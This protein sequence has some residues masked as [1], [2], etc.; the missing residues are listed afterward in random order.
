MNLVNY[1]DSENS[2][3]ESPVIPKVV[4]KPVAAK[5]SF[6]KVVDSSNPRKI[7]VNLPTTS[8]TRSSDG[9]IDADGPPAKKARTDGV[10]SNFNSL[11]PAPKK[12]G[13]D[14]KASAAK[15]GSG[16][17]LGSGVS[18]KTG[19]APAFSRAP[20]EADFQ[21]S[22]DGQGENP[23]SNGTAATGSSVPEVKE[24]M[25]LVGK[26][27]MFKPLSVMNKVKK[28]KKVIPD[29]LS[30][31]SSAQTPPKSSTQSAQQTGPPLK[32]TVSL[33]SISQDETEAQVST[34]ASSEED[35]RT[36]DSDSLLNE[37][38]HAGTH[39]QST[40]S[41][42]GKGAQSLDAI[43]DDLNL[44]EAA[45]RQLFGRQRGKGAA[46]L[47]AAKII[48]FNTDE[49]YLANEKLRAAGETI[50][51]NP[52]RAIAPGKHNLKQMV[53]NAQSQ[54]EAFEEHFATGKR[55]KAEAGSKYGW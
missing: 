19:A 20:V 46:D 26:N 10:F 24:E 27:T 2:D 30:A 22:E 23:K 34:T 4:P 31:D 28:K 48:N 39:Y 16:G 12:I 43:A 45:R 33:F 50:Q 51:H 42:S 14:N 37:Q 6:Q 38:Q 1:S 9:D 15:R 17:G 44:S 36:I 40:L 18:L 8:N 41:N 3:N 55:N 7:K 54:K 29:S 35:T 52:V 5:P 32:Q 13:G 53:N 47:S 11:L 25:K 21:E 49:E